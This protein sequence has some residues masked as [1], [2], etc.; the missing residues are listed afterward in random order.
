MKRTTLFKI[1]T[2]LNSFAFPQWNKVG[3]DNIGNTLTT[4]MYVN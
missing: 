1:L 3:N 2:L 4:K